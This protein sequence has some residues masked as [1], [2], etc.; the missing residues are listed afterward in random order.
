MRLTLDGDLYRDAMA[1][2]ELFAKKS[3]DEDILSC[4]NY[5]VDGHT[6]TMTASDG[7][8][9]I[10]VAMKCVAADP[11]PDQKIFN[12][13]PQKIDRG[14]YN[15]DID[16]DAGV[17]FCTGRR[18]YAVTASPVLPL[19][20]PDLVAACLKMFDDIV[21]GRHMIY[22]G[23]EDKTIEHRFNPEYLIR[24]GT[25]AKKLGF[26]NWTTMLMGP[27]RTMPMYLENT[28][29]SYKMRLWILPVLGRDL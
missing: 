26:K 11:V 4:I 22:G 20:Y 13:L 1:V 28:D 6:V 2:L 25:A 16:T 5:I 15:V 23:V 9:L 24:A 19:E 21:G 10:M 7:Y 29:E 3:H 17:V 12:L 27:G 8:A 14:V 18:N